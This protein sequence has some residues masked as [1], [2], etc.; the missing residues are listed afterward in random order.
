[1]PKYTVSS[2]DFEIT[3]NRRSPRKAA[4]AAIGLLRESEESI[5]LGILTG[6]FSADGNGLYF[7]TVLLM[8][9]NGIKYRKCND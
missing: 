9:E 4:M 8:E 1:M 2:G 5:I 7:S 6:V 3:I